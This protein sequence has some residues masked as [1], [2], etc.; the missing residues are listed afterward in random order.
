LRPSQRDKQ[1][2]AG[3]TMAKG[4]RQELDEKTAENEV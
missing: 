2:S 1:Y 4:V 3:T